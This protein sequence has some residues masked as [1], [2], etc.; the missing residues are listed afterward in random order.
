MEE[1]RKQQVEALVE[2]VKELVRKGN[3]SRIIVKRKGEQVFSI[4]VNVG[5]VG[6]VL[7]LAAAPWALVA[8]ALASY[9]LDCRIE[10]QKTDGETVELNGKL[11]GEKVDDLG[12]TVRERFRRAP[13]EE[14]T[15]PTD[16]VIEF[17]VED[18]PPEDKSP[19]DE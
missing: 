13:E 7:G 5:V 4:P 2:K 17:V 6:A 1:N 15:E 8:A 12:E 10:V 16:N 19:E 9:G 11:V 3:V 18:E 14:P